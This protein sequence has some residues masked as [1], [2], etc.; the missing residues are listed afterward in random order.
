MA[1]PPDCTT[2]VPPSESMGS[3]EAMRGVA[4]LHPASRAVLLA[5]G[6]VV[7]G[8]LFEQ[9]ATL[10]V[11][12]LI[13]ILIAIPLSAV[14]TWLERFRIP[15]AV[16]ALIGLLIGLGI[17]AG[18][19]ALVI[20]AFVDEVRTF[21]DQAPSIFDALKS[22]IANV[23]GD[24]PSQVGVQIKDF[25]NG[26]TNDPAKLIGPI[27]TIGTSIVTAL[28]AILVILITAYYMAVRPQPLVDG[29]L[30]IFPPESREQA[31]GVMERLRGAWIG[32]MQGILVGMFIN[33][34]LLW[35]GLQLIGLDFAVLFAVFSAV[36]ILIPYFGTPLGAIPPVA[37][38]LSQSPGTALVVLAIYVGV[39][40]IESYVTMPLV[41]ANRVKLQPAVVAIGVIVIGELFGFIGLFVAVPILSLVVILVDEL[42]VKPT[43]DRRKVEPASNGEVAQVVASSES[44]QMPRAAP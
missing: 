20:P 26:Y 8:L 29:A 2:S 9:L 25:I 13:T 27:A 3:A 12:I 6:L 4:R 19:L 1:A 38:G 18:I 10:L 28:A 37:Y 33:G 30:R 23:S 39:H 5:F 44:E 34:F 17:L 36:L 11:A 40:A 24:Q 41:M 43:E 7:L 21:A 31:R 15:R 42:W 35:V 14:A 32:W 16:G 22:K